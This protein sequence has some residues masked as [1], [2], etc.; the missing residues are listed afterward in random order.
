MKIHE[1]KEN[2]TLTEIAEIY[3]I[4]EDYLA[5]ING[6][7]ERAISIGEELLVLC[8]TRIHT[9]KHGD[10]LERLCMRYRVRKCDLIA[11][12]PEL[13]TD[14][15]EPGQRIALKLGERSHGMAATNGYIYRG[16][17]LDALKRRLPYMTYATFACYTADERG[18]HGLYDEKE[19]LEEVKK[20]GTIPLLRVHDSYSERYK[21]KDNTE[22]FCEKLI[23]LAKRS[24]YKGVCLNSSAFLHSAKEYSEFIVNFKKMMI[25]SDLILITECDEKTP[26]E[27][28]DLA[29]GSVLSYTKLWDDDPPSFDLGE[30]K[31]ISDFAC[32]CESVKSFIELPSFA[33][34][35]DGFTEIENAVKAAR[36]DAYRVTCN[37][38][39]KTISFE[40]RQGKCTYPS[41]SN[42]KAVLE[43]LSEYGYMGMSFDVMRTPISYIMMYN[44]M[45][46]TVNHINIS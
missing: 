34:L 3:G 27:F 30:R 26:S 35:G 21:G 33:R 1:T 20:S 36:K 41:L 46:K 7:E 29:D 18:I 4:N 6:V 15:F 12:N 38:D 17:S 9:A 31:A 16:T 32:D 19:L 40:T 25:G 14:K 39:L 22:S 43:L 42:I 5:S 37:H 28:C 45:F 11:Q 13:C 23:E 10:T 2:E 8:P 44:A 24:N